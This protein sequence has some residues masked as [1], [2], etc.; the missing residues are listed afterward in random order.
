MRKATLSLLALL[1]L[2]SV[3]IV[4]N[5]AA[6]DA[7]L[8]R[9][10]VKQ[11]E[12]F[13]MNTTTT[14]KTTT[15][16]SGQDVDVEQNMEFGVAYS[17]DRVQPDGSLDVTCTYETIK[18]SVKSSMMELMYDSKAPKKSDKQLAKAFGPMVGASIQMRMSPTGRVLEVK[19]VKELTTK[20]FASMSPTQR[21][22]MEKWIT[23]QSNSNTIMAGLNQYPENPVRIGESWNTQT[24][25]DLGFP[26]NV[27]TTYVLKG[28]Q[29]GSNM[30][31]VNAEITSGPPKTAAKGAATPSHL[32]GSQSGTVEVDAKTGLPIRGRIG[33][34]ISAEMASEQNGK[35]VITPVTIETVVVTKA[36]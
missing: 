15:R 13:H 17:F 22:D 18:F 3:L 36:Y 19:G 7:V 8:L 6:D 26:V 14:Q 29:G 2:I 11:G 10:N 16:V 35:T 23:A 32:K 12:V 30:I 5:A 21:Q 20:M 33:G 31:G 27:R 24:A 4:P 34:K 28:S 9:L 25:V 1:L